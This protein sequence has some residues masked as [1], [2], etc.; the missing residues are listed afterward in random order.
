MKKDQSEM[1]LEELWHLYPIILSEHK[2]CW[3]DWYLEEKETLKRILK[4]DNMILSHI[5]STSV[6]TIWA[7]PTVDILVEADGG[8]FSAVFKT[9]TKHG[10]VHMYRTKTHMSFVK[11]YLPEGFAEKVYHIHVRL[12]GDNDELYFRDYLIE[13]PET[14]KEYETLKLGLWKPFEFDRDGYTNAKGEFVKAVTEK[15]KRLYHCRYI[16]SEI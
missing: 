14:A 8:D 12:F 15:A 5:G 2:D 1:S 6:D 4:L 3:K 7:K 10:Y 11:G 16:R 9:L 13:H